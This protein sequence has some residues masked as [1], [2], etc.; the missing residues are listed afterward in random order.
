MSH[1]S[2]R[3]QFKDYLDKLPADLVLDRF[4]EEDESERKILSSKFISS[5]IEKS[6]SYNTIKMKFDDLSKE[7]Q[8]LV[9]LCYLSG[10]AGLKVNIDKDTHEELLSSF[11]IYIMRDDEA[12]D[13]LYGFTDFDDTFSGEF[14][15]EYIQ[16]FQF[17][18][19]AENRPFYRY[20]ALNDL[21]AV[22]NVA[23]R[24]ELKIKKNGELTLSA[25]S[26][27]KKITHM[28]IDT[29]LFYKKSIAFA[30]ITKFLLHFAFE[31]GL[32]YKDGNQLLVSYNKASTWIKNTPKSN[33]EAFIQSVKSYCGYWNE[34]LL[35]NFSVSS[36][37]LSFSDSYSNE[38]LEF[39]N[40]IQLF[41]YSG[42]FGA[43]KESK[44][45]AICNVPELWSED[46]Q[47]SPNTILIMPDFSVMISQT[48]SPELLYE[49][50]LLGE[51]TKLDKVY[52]GKIEKSTLSDSLSNGLKGEVVINFLEKWRTPANIVITVKEWITEFHRISIDD[53]KF[54]FI[55]DKETMSAIG[56][57]PQLSDF[58]DEVKTVSVY[59]IKPGY[60]NRVMSTLDSFGFDIRTQ[61]SENV[62]YEEPVELLPSIERKNAEMTVVT[63][64][65]MKKVEKPSSGYSS[66][67]KYSS[68]LKELSHH[69]LI[70]V[71][72]Y[73]ILM[74]SDLVI[75]YNGG[76]GVRK[77]MY[78]G[79]P[80]K[81]TG[82]NGS[83]LELTES[84]SNKKITLVIDEIFRIAVSD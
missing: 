61:N 42:I 82:L 24:G 19:S 69:D 77:G 74:E 34:A 79:L 27:L 80:N 57:H 58:I 54:V 39:Y 11:L 47:D 2:N 49:F 6:T 16:H 52:K 33:Y 14:F 44:S 32:I 28:S 51:L 41:H 71:I 1:F 5:I 64:F 35:S 60:E 26:E 84:D 66:G 31:Q 81:I 55:S 4:A 23:A 83:L 75:D 56:S 36:E 12:C 68:T 9:L 59:K 29:I 53:G 8:Q 37:A 48:V 7:S 50:S 3:F 17:K 30:N 10:Q 67:G 15:E 46:P 13:T 20:R 65:S 38:N 62:S 40:S 73:A 43:V 72:D 22:L 76:E 63:D 21:V 18:S 45:S 25:N 78:T 70:Q